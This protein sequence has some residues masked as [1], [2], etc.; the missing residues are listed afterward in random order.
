MARQKKIEKTEEK[1]VKDE[2]VCIRIPR[3][4]FEKISADAEK[5]L[6]TD[7]K[8]LEFILRE[9]YFEDPQEEDRFAT[10]LKILSRTE[11]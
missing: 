3:K 6:R 10:F 4:Y 9:Y 7:E 8:Q 11:E 1:A 2:Y 5:C